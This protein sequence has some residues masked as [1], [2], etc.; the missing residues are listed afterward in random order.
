MRPTQVLTACA[1]LLIVAAVAQASVPWDNPS[2]SAGTFD[3]ANG[4]N[5]DTDLFG[6]PNYYGG[7][8]FYFL[9]SN[10][11]PYADDGGTYAIATDTL[12]VDLL[13]HAAW[14]F[15]EI[16]WYEY[17]DYSITG[18]D[19]NQ[20]SASL[21]MTVTVPGHPMSPFQDSFSFSASGASAGAWDDSTGVVLDLTGLG[22]PPVTE[23]HLTFTNTL[24]AL[25]DGN[26]GTASIS[27]NFV[28][29]PSIITIPIPEPSALLLLSLGGFLVAG[30]PRRIT[31]DSWNT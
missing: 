12:N 7:D 15:A 24:T 2:G 16:S 18:G 26:G 30:R 21:E 3:W 20:V 23:L 5:S 29:G 8:G 19:G 4:Y 14:Q 28:I 11:D 31:W 1:A 13:A 27:G 10:F 6:S 25:S 17:G 22:M 9:S